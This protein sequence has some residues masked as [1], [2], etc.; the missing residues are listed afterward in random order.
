MPVDHFVGR[1]DDINRLAAVLTGEERA[2][3]KLTVQSIEGPGGIGKT[4]LFDHVLKT[5]DLG[6]RNYLTLKIDGN[7]D[8]ND[9]SAKSLVKTVARLVASAEADALR[10]RPAGFYFPPVGGVTKAIDRI[11]DEAAAEFRKRNPDCEEGRA[12]LLRFLDL[13]VEAGK[14]V[15]DAIPITKKYVNVRELEKSEKTFG[16]N[17]SHLGQPS[18]GRRRL[19][20]AQDRMVQRSAGSE[21]FDPG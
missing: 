16:R 7:V 21:E 6:G 8:G 10:D 15:N 3:G 2:A 4:C 9:P 5:T 12:A 19:S 11:R 1:Q 17:G 13:A 14:G 20:G 18:T